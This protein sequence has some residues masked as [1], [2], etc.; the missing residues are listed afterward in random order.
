MEG[1]R[2]SIIEV[3]KQAKSYMEEREMRKGKKASVLLAA[4]SS[5]LQALCSL[6]VD[7]YALNR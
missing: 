2:A 3:Y 7:P 6:H 5:R 4:G 1:L